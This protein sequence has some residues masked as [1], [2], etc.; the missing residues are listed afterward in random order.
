MKAKSQGRK[1][2]WVVANSHPRFQLTV[3]PRRK[4][5]DSNERLPAFFKGGE[6]KI[7]RHESY[8]FRSVPLFDSEGK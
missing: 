8:C 1:V 7:K 5:G 3:Q 6:I 2:V 4:M